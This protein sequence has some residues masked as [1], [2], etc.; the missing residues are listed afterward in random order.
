MPLESESMSQPRVRLHADLEI[1][2]RESV[3]G[4]RRIE[5]CLKDCLGV[6]RWPAIGLL[7][8]I[9]AWYVF[10]WDC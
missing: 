8:H 2:A 10:I 6:L 9:T 5:N 3:C 7:S 1:Q 4:W